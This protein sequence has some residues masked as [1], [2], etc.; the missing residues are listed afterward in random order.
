MMRKGIETATPTAEDESLLSEVSTPL[1][2][3]TILREK[4]I[5]YTVYG[6]RHS[7]LKRNDNTGHSKKS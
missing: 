6:D 2:I 3:A 5:P 7:S 1:I 4:G